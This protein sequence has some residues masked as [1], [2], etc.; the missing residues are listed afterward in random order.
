M[1]PTQLTSPNQSLYH[2]LVAAQHHTISA[3]SPAV[4]LGQVGKNDLDSGSRSVKVSSNLVS[5]NLVVGSHSTDEDG[6]SRIDG[7]SEVLGLKVQ[8]KA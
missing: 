3:D 8:T 7:I 1:L 4:A 5:L 2:Q 6:D